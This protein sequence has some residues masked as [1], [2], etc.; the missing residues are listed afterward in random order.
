MMIDD[1]FEAIAA[2]ASSFKSD[3]EMF[4]WLFKITLVF[5]AG[6]ALVFG[7]MGLVI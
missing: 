6:A 1:F 7:L 2:K 4:V 3:E 5:L